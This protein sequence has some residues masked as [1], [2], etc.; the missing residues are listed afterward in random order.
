MLRLIKYKQEEMILPTLEQS[1]VEDAL[2][3]LL[4]LICEKT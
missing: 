4:F 1:H 3:G 2:V